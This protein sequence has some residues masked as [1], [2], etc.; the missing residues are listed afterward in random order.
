MK[1]IIVST[2]LGFVITSCASKW[3]YKIVTIKSIEKETSKFDPNEFRVSDESLNLFGE[4]GWELV[5]IYTTIETVHPNFGNTEYVNGI[6]P[7][8]RNKEINFLFKRKK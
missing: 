5:D 8:V 6:Q 1:K 7:N 4:K 2:L 3:E